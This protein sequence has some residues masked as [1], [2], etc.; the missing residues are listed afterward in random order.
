M[1]NSASCTLANIWKVIALKFYCWH[2]S[3]IHFVN[4]L[5]RTERPGDAALASRAKWA[6]KAEVGS[7]NNQEGAFLPHF[8]AE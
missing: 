6:Q 3:N 7:R 8:T 2:R 5:V 1:N 4:T